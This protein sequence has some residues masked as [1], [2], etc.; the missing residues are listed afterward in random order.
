MKPATSSSFQEGK[1]LLT[2]L[3]TTSWNFLAHTR[4]P[5][6]RKYFILVR[7]ENCVMGSEADHPAG[8]TAHPRSELF[9]SHIGNWPY[10]TTPISHKGGTFKEKTYHVH[11]HGLLS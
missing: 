11:V 10:L 6:G 9:L 5:R 7:K 4:Q 2:S 1:L 8:L 3:S